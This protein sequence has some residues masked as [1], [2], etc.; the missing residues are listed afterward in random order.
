MT[1]LRVLGLAVA[2]V[3][4]ASA[5]AQSHFPAPPTPAGNP[6]TTPKALLGMALFWEEQMSSTNSVACGTCHQFS[7]GGVDPRAVNQRHPG[8]DGIPNTADDILGARGVPVREASGHYSGSATF[9]LDPQVT[10]R[11]APTVINSAYQPAL[12]YDGR[13][14]NGEFRDPITNQ[15][16]LTGP[17]AL[18]NL[19][20]A[21]PVNSTEMAH[22]GRTWTDVTNKIATARPL[23]LASNIPSRLATFIGGATTYNQLFEQVY[24][25]GASATPTRIIMAIATY[26]RTL[27]SDQSPFDRSVAGQGALSAAAQRGMTLFSTPQANAAACSQCHGDISTASH[28]FGPTPLQ[29][30]MYGQLPVPNSHNTGIRPIADDNGVGGITTNQTDMGRFR[31][32]GLRNTALHGTWFH[33]GGLTTLAQV[34]DFYDRGGDFHTNQATEIQPRNLSA[35]QKA[36]LVAFLDALTDPRVVAGQAPFDSPRLGSLDNVAPTRSGTGMTGSAGRAPQAV[37]HE[38]VVI[39]GQSATIAVQNVP[40][41]APTFVAW[42][43]VAVPQGYNYAGLQLYIGL[44]DVAV[45][46][47][48]TA[49]PSTGGAGFASFPFGVPSL[50]SLVGTNL[51]AQWLVFDQGAPMG[52]TT[53]DLTHIVVR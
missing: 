16:V 39:G 38:P 11:K 6:V 9:G 40:A 32:P 51:Y 12:F 34:V 21:P 45:T 46:Y 33:T 35:Q 23:A 43:T 50:R 53:S 13:V 24:G 18:E 49:R 19:V 25:P 36:D 8:R 20:A 31:T 42:D 44:Y 27:N 29:T 17:V 4:G 15:V 7:H 10:Q 52:V 26:L 3:L 5:F 22:T 41:N 1:P 2:S 48:G 30:T 47:A 28:Q 14:A 37:A